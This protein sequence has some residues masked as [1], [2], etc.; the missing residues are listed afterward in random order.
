MRTPRPGCPGRRGLGLAPRF[1]R[2][3]SVGLC[4]PIALVLRMAG[5]T[6][7]IGDTGFG[8]ALTP[9]NCARWLV[10]Y[11]HAASCRQAAMADWAWETVAYRI[12][13]GILGL[14]A[15][16]IFVA[17]RRRIRRSG[18]WAALPA[19]VA[20]TIAVTIFAVSGL[21]LTG[22]C[23]DAVV[24]HSGNG[25]GSWLSA[26]PMALGATVVFGLRLLHD[27]RDPHVLPSPSL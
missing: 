25:A 11:P 8:A 14:I 19:P 4:G 17:V 27:L 23:V 12:V 5:G 2:R 1:D 3:P 24:V 22:M 18:R 10:G 9:P 6:Q 13:L 16:A 26:A 7:F 21:W 15:P 20:D